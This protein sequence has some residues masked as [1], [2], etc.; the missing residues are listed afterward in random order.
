LQLLTVDKGGLTY[1]PPIGEHENIAE[2]SRVGTE[3]PYKKVPAVFS[4][5]LSKP[6]VRLSPHPAF[7]Q[8]VV[9]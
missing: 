1:Q 5:P 2:I 9:G 4:I 8:V 7:H 3:T 6:D